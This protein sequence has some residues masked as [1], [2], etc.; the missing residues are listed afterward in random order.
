MSNKFQQIMLYEKPL[1]S[2]YELSRE[3]VETNLKLPAESCFAYI[4]K[5]ENQDLTNSGSIA[6]EGTVILSLCG[7]TVGSKLSNTTSG[8]LI[9]IV[10]HFDRDVLKKVFEGKKPKYWRE[11]DQPLIRDT[12]QEDASA[13]VRSY[14]VGISHFFKHKSALNEDILTLKLKEIV[15]LLLQTDEPSE[16]YII[17][18]SL[19]SEKVFSFQEVIEAH[20]Y[21]PLDLIRLAA[22]TNNSL[23]S[24]KR[25]FRKIYNDPP[26][27][28]IRKKKL[29][30]ARKLVISSQKSMSE[31]CYEC[32]FSNPSGFSRMFKSEFGV[33]PFEYRLSR[34]AH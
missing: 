3:P 18:R 20:I 28:Y 29:E 24:F 14:F 10:V 21:E 13:L 23:A 8:N 33:S 30:G 12:A 25:K 17:A 5:G 22:M 26:G 32:G 11:L 1:F 2:W 7:K 9:S 6:R 15:F 16:L 31:I 4:L 19:F 34:S 27:R